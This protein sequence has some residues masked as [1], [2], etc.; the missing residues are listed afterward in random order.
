MSSYPRCPECGSVC[1]AAVGDEGIGKNLRMCHSC[2]W[3]Y[4]E[5]GFSAMYPAW[6]GLSRGE[7]EWLVAQRKAN[8]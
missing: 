2:E 4:Q 7:R 8:A 1:S 3:I 5:G 6:V